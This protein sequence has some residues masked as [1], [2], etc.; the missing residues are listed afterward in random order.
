MC[1]L[2]KRCVKLEVLNIFVVAPPRDID[3]WHLLHSTKQA[4]SW[5]IPDWR[6]LCHYAVNRKRIFQNSCAFLRMRS[7]YISIGCDYNEYRLISDC[8]YRPDSDCLTNYRCNTRIYQSPEHCLATIYFNQG[9]LYINCCNS[10]TRTLIQLKFGTL[11]GYPEVIISINFGG[12]N[13]NV[14]N[15]GNYQYLKA[16]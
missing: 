15:Y 6:M 5:V 14:R 8:Y 13:F 2:R 12:T 3:K 4:S 11:V 16:S 10:Q 1:L 9:Y 7:L